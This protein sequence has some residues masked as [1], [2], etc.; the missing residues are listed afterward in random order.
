MLLRIA[1]ALVATLAALAFAALGTAIV[2][3]PVDSPLLR[4]VGAVTALYG[5]VSV[6]LIAASWRAPSRRWSQLAGWLSVFF[7]VSWVAGSFD[8]GMLSGQ[9]LLMAAFVA[10]AGA[11]IWLGVRVA[12]GLAA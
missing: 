10:S 8:R 11:A 6:G 7:V 2:I 5:F 4:M 9:E 12:N 3:G 1:G